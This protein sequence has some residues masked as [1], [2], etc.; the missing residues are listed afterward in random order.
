MEALIGVRVDGGLGV[1]F[2]V[3]NRRR[4]YSPNLVEGRFSDVHMQNR[5]YSPGTPTD[6][7]ATN[8][9]GPELEPL[10]AAHRHK[11]ALRRIRVIASGYR[12]CGGRG[13]QEFRPRVCY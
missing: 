13:S 12:L 6:S 2:C 11:G 8:T 4:V 7:A 10:H 1:S 3:F 5:A 9:Q